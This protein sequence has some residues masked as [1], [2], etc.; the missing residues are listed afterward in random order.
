M[1]LH[2]A[3]IPPPNLLSR[4]SQSPVIS[5]ISSLT[6]MTRAAGN[7]ASNINFC[8]IQPFPSISALQNNQLLLSSAN[9]NS[10]QPSIPLYPANLTPRP[11]EFRPHCPAKDRLAKWVP[12]PD[13]LQKLGTLAA[14]DL[15][16]HVKLVIIQ[17]WSEQTRA[18]YCVGLLVYHVF[19][20]SWN[21]SKQERAPTSTNL[22][23]MFISVL[24][25]IYS[26]RTIHGYIY[27]V[28]AWHTVNG[29]P[30]ELHKDQISTMLKG[31]AS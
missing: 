21:I 9:N 2:G 30:W 18:S 19:C 7:S 25:G 31:A 22:I 17:G 29:L 8:S 12:H 16:D 4:A 11:L 20:D 3:S 23:S 10:S 14:P 28:H 5:P 24:L 15:Q 27:S 6:L 1:A 13:I 26:G